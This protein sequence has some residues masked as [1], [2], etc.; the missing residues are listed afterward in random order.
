MP[1]PHD[2]WSN[3]ILM[4]LLP[5]SLVLLIRLLCGYVGRIGFVVQGNAPGRGGGPA[6]HAVTIAADRGRVVCWLETSMAAPVTGIPTGISVR[7]TVYLLPPRPPELRRS[8]WEF[9]AHTLGLVRG[10]NVFLLACPIWC[11]A[12]L[13]L[14]ARRSR[15]GGAVGKGKSKRGSRWTNNRLISIVRRSG[16]S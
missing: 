3:R 7:D 15:F 8:I 2:A 4:V 13:C 16:Q 10:A 11:V 1:N 6:Y 5:L 12:A 14:I 9:D